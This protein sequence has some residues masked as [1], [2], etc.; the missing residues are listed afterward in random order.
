MNQTR[1][2]TQLLIG[3]VIFP[4]VDQIDF[5]GPFEVFSRI[6]NVTC[7]TLAKE[8]G[9]LRDG[10]GLILN[11]YAIFASLVWLKKVDS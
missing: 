4:R 7:V 8:R 9:P 1:P 6:P 2:S 3:S 5:T 10:R 11:D